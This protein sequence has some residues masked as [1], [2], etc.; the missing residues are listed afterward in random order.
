LNG[1]GDELQH[2]ADDEEGEEAPEGRVLTRLHRVRERNR[3]LVAQRKSK[4]LRDL[5]YLRCEVCA[6]DFQESY[7]E[8]GRGFIEVHHTRPLAMLVEEVKTKLEDLALLCANCHRMV[9]SRRPWLSLNELRA[10]IRE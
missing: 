9:H 2:G 6:F 7:G 1:A 3:K 4:A 8:R 5:G 10:V